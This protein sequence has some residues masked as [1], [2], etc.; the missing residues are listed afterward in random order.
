M[1]YGLYVIIT[2]FSHIPLGLLTQTTVVITFT[3]SNIPFMETY[4]D[5]SSSGY[6]TL[7]TSAR[8]VV[9]IHSNYTK[10][11]LLVLSYVG[12]TRPISEI[13]NVFSQT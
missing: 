10:V 3:I 8:Q 2:Y 4:T 9:S 11:M 6:V 5:S 13:L 12:K 7:V 1:E